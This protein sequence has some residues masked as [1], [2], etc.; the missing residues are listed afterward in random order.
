VSR[1]ACGLHYDRHQ[2]IRDRLPAICPWSLPWSPLYL[3]AFRNLRIVRPIRFAELAD[4]GIDWT[5]S[6]GVAGRFNAFG[7]RD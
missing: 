5:F 4:K 6:A 3:A 2:P 1:N 7:T